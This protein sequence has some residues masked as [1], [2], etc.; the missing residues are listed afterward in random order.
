MK[1]LKS[2][3]KV[4]KV[5]QDKDIIGLVAITQI[6]SKSMCLENDN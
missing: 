3:L 2:K 1:A 4:D 6:G 5:M